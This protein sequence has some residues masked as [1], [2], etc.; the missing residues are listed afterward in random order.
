M[1]GHIQ[2]LLDKQKL[3]EKYLSYLAGCTFYIFKSDFQPASPF[4]PLSLLQRESSIYFQLL[5]A[6]TLVHLILNY[7]APVSLPRVLTIVNCLALAPFM[8]RTNNLPG[9]ENRVCN[10][11][12]HILILI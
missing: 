12:G 1:V 3:K 7:F 2:N 10:C 11:N 9:F 5:I 6:F 8:L 4:S